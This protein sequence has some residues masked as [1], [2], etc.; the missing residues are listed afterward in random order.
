VDTAKEARLALDPSVTV[1]QALEPQALAAALQD[2]TEFKGVVGAGRY[3][4]GTPERDAQ[5]L[6]ITSRG[7]LHAG[8][9]C[10]ADLAAGAQAGARVVS[11]TGEAAP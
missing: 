3:F 9:I 7:I 4:G 8:T 11:K 5:V 6:E 10:S 2:I 1:A